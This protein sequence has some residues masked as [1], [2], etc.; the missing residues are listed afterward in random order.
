MKNRGYGPRGGQ[1]ARKELEYHG[2]DGVPSYDYDGE[3][4]MR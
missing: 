1:T 4:A 3:P 2:L